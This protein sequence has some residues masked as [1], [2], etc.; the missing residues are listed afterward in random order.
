MTVMR[1]AAEVLVP[2]S[3]AEAAALFGDGSGV[4]V[5]AGGTIVMP[6]LANGRLRPEKALV[7]ARAGLAGVRRSGDTITIGATTPV[8]EL[9][10]LADP[11]GACAAN[12]ADREIRSQ[13]TLGGNL[14][15]GAGADAPRGDLQSA[16]LALD[17]VVRSTG[18]QGEVTEPIEQ[19]LNAGR[20]LLL[21][22]SFQEPAAGAF[23]AIEYPHTQAY[24][25]L[26]VSGARGA[27]GSVRLAATGLAGH[28]ARLRSAEAA[29]SDPIAAGSA[30][31]DD[32]A[33]A[34]DAVASAWYRAKTL[35]VLVR[36][37]L[38]Q[39]EESA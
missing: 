15:A 21:D 34:D 6:L 13:A 14:K 9:V 24:T 25:V 1:T 2:T 19:F 4:T 10:G 23:A 8:Q 16:L 38:A 17:A 7:L 26:A 39:L 3:A 37:V 33:F 11:L 35:P 30:A 32:V 5:V 27:D 18:A 28:G 12:V 31:L 22:V 36:R 29:S 20:R